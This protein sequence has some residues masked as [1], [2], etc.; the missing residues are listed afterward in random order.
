MEERTK[1]R[2]G[3]A[4]MSPERQR[5]IASKGGKTAHARGTAHQW[6]R[7]AA[8]AAGSKGGA[9]TGRV[10]RERRLREAG[11]AVRSEEKPHE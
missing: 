11:I 1:Q 7:E 2:R 9:A 3:F 5:E 6:D 4:A 8:Q 10:M